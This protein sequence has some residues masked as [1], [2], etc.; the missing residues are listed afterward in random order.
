[1]PA[2][3]IEAWG[4][5]RLNTYNE[6]PRKAKY[7][8]IDR[9]QEPGSAAMDRGNE[10]DAALEGYIR[11]HRND[12]HPELKG[13]KKLKKLLDQ[14]RAE[15]KEGRVKVQMELAFDKAW[16]RCEWFAKETYVRIKIDCLRLSGDGKSVE[17]I[18]WK[19]GKLHSF[20][21]KPEYAGQVDLYAVAGLIAFPQV[22]VAYPSLYFVDHEVQVSAPEGQPK[23]EKTRKELAKAQKFWDKQAK[24]MLTD[25]MFPPR[26]GSACRW[27]HFTKNKEGPCEF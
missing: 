19:S 1:M 11:S 2:K 21:S 13:K 16:K 23:A 4:P 26:P 3:K 18:D 12:L 7:K 9:L 6:C 20:E 10:I 15:Y 22:D 14:L 25:T 8:F 17:V 24:P 5:S 27:C